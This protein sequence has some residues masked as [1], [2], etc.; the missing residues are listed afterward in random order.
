MDDISLLIFAW[1]CGFAGGFTTMAVIAIHIWKKG[2]I[3]TTHR[4]FRR[5]K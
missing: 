5:D 4:M 2:N 1:M 3:E